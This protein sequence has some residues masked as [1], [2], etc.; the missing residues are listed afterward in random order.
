MKEK[1]G[2]TSCVW[3]TKEGGPIQRSWL[4]V[5]NWTMV[6]SGVD[7]V[8]FSQHC[9]LRGTSPVYVLGSFVLS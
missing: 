2:E 6:S 1:W 4:D 7:S 9:L 3:P 5:E 8:Q